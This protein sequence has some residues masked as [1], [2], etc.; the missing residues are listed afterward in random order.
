MQSN[1]LSFLQLG[2]ITLSVIPGIFS[3]LHGTR[4]LKI[5]KVGLHD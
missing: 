1:A 3:L 5:F 2:V 4:L